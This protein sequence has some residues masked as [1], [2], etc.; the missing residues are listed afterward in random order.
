MELLNGSNSNT[1]L[2][3]SIETKE[4]GVACIPGI[5][6]MQTIALDVEILKQYPEYYIEICK[7]LYKKDHP[8]ETYK[9]EPNETKY[10]FDRFYKIQF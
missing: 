8:R 9:P 4:S 7:K 6:G 5:D 10:Y 2:T 3:V 1:P